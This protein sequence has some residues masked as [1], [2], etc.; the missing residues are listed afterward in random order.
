M[1]HPEDARDLS[2]LALAWDMPLSTLCF[3]VLH[4]WLQRARHRR[5]DLGEARGGLMMLIEMALADKELGPWMREEV[6][7]DERGD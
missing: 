7:R 2:A 3:A 6:S 4:E 5:A 1:L